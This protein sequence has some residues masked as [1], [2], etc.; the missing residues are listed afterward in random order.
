MRSR[1][2]DA[3][4]DDAAL[5]GHRA[6]L[7][8]LRCHPVERTDPDDVEG[9]D[10]ESGGFELGDRVGR[11]ACR[12]RRAPGLVGGPSEMTTDTVDALLHA[13]SRCQATG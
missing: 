11:A 5:G 3:E 6:A 10:F 12:R 8:V 4:A 2:D 1:L 9:L 13:G 7:G